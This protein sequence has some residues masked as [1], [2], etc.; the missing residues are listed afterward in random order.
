[1]GSSVCFILNIIEISILIVSQ[2][3]VYHRNKQVTEE[4]KALLLFPLSKIP[5]PS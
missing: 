4:K 1:M 3:G 5:P 2:R